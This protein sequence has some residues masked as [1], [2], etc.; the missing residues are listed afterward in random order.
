MTPI[1]E[2]LILE[3]SETNQSVGTV[4]G[5]SPTLGVDCG[6]RIGDVVFTTEFGGVKFYHK[7]K[8][9]LWVTIR[10][11]LGLCPPTLVVTHSSFM[12]SLQQ[13]YEAQI[14]RALDSE[15]ATL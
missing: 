2:N 8:L 4:V 6:V 3:I 9:Y 1:F 5:I 12:E 15:L 10:E 11:V 7:D 13:S 14:N